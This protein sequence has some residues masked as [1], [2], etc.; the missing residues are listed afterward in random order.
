MPGLLYFFFAQ[1]LSHNVEAHVVLG[2]SNPNHVSLMQVMQMGKVHVGFVE[3]DNFS[4]ANRLAKSPRHFRIGVLAPVHDGKIRQKGLQIQI[5]VHFRRRFL[6][7]MLRPVHAFRN[8]L[9][10]C[11]IYHVDRSPEPPRQP[12]IVPISGYELRVLF[13][14]IAQYCPK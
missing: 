4:G 13:L 12:R 8:E 7:P 1:L 11:G 14:D 3:N 2:A 6:L 5:Q 10:R 9:N